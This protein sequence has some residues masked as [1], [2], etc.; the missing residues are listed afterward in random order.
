[1]HSL[2]KSE[3]IVVSR[4]DIEFL[5]HNTATSLRLDGIIWPTLTHYTYI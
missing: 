4:A 1:M 5:S 3:A 2:I